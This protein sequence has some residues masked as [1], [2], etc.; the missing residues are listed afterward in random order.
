MKANKDASESPLTSSLLKKAILN[1]F[2][3]RHKKAG[4]APFERLKK[5]HLDN[6]PFTVENGILTP[7]LK[8]VWTEARKVYKDIIKSLYDQPEAKL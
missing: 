2:E 6:K 1:D 4:L 7:S 3:E 8:L 5:I